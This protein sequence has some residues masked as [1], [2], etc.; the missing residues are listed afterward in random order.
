MAGVLK[1]T[2]DG[3]PEL[4]RLTGRLAVAK[5]R[6][7]H[8]AKDRMV[9]EV[10][11]RSPRH[12]G[13]KVHGEVLEPD[14]IEVGT[15][16]SRDAKALDQGATILPHGHPFLKFENASGVHFARRTVIRRNRPGG[17]FFERALSH[18]VQ[19]MDDAFT[20]TFGSELHRDG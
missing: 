19:I 17:R 6:M 3:L 7:L 15:V 18:R 13:A 10:V 12:V 1:A 5:D 11:K 2:V 9:Q 16:G 20:E 14:E 8:R 4:E